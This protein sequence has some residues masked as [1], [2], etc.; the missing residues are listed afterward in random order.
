MAALRYFGFT[1]NEKKT[2]CEGPF[3]ES[4][5]GDFFEGQPVR[6]YFLKK[7]PDEPSAWMA[8][9]NGVRLVDPG[10]K[11]LRAAW[12]FAVDQIPVKF[13]VFG[14]KELGDTVIYDP[15]AEPT[16]RKYSY[17]CSG[18]EVTHVIHPSWRIYRPVSVRISV[19]KYFSSDIAMVSYAMGVG[20]HVTPRES[21]SGYK[22]SW[23]SAIGVS[24]PGT[25]LGLI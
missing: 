22:L 4:C 7:L 1:P 21:V 2:F 9:A 20:S 24:D 23:V 15:S 8:V 12:R 5:G 14:P 11:R 3:R 13:R 10:L 6:A 16:L 25:V 19:E 18:G 17:K